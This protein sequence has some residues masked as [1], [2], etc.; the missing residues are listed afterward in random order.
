MKAAQRVKEGVIGHIYWSLKLLESK[1]LC[2]GSCV[3]DP[4]FRC[5]R[6]GVSIRLSSPILLVIMI[7][8]LPVR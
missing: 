4:A 6:G 8:L 5:L 3:E 7:A 1:R 2:R